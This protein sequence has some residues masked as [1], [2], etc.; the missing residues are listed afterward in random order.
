[1]N[2][3]SLTRGIV[4][5]AM[6]VM[7]VALCACRQKA[8]PDKA[9]KNVEQHQGKLPADGESQNVTIETKGRTVEIMGAV[10]GWPKEIP[11][12]V[13]QFSFGTI[14]RVIR[15]ETPEGQS[16]DLVVE[17]VRQHAIRDYEAILKSSGFLTSSM[18][19]TG[20]EGERGSVTGEKGAVTIVLISTNGN[21]SLS[22]II[23]K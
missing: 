10:E 18:I 7:T 14:R 8:V 22:V 17:S 20:K 11:V 1:M 16:W 12:E 5:T 3:A 19:V 13:P 4:V 15:T 9:V 21:S 23:K 2:R 6:I